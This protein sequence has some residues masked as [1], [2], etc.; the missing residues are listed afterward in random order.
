MSKL[1][2]LIVGQRFH[3]EKIMCLDKATSIS[4][5][6]LKAEQWYIEHTAHYVAVMEIDV[7]RQTSAE[8]LRT[9]FYI[10]RHCK[11][12]N[13]QRVFKFKNGTTYAVCPICNIVF[14][15][16]ER[17]NEVPQEVE[18]PVEMEMVNEQG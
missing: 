5:A 14:G 8:K 16:E 13:L 4:V 18:E 17:V 15:M 3:Y 11:C 1:P 7:Q 12:Q 2:L 10:R 9:V 6:E